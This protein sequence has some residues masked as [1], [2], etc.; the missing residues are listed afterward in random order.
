MGLLW[1]S[2]LVVGVVVF[3]VWWVCGEFVGVADWIWLRTPD[4][5]VW[6]LE[7][8]LGGGWIWTFVLLGFSVV[9]GVAC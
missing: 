8:L 7:T 6:W 2:F 5:G 1:H 4:C 3:W 9:L